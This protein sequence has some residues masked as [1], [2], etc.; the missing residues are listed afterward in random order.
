M[1]PSCLCLCLEMSP[2]E[3]PNLRPVVCGSL[4]VC[5][6]VELAPI[7]PGLHQFVPVALADGLGRN[8]GPDT[9]PQRAVLATPGSAPRLPPRGQL[10]AGRPAPAADCGRVAG[11]VARRSHG[12]PSGERVRPEQALTRVSLTG[13]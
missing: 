6:C 8:S 3:A 1:H 11:E 7:F 10:H 2:L 13:A 9:G 12:V 4:I 5:Q